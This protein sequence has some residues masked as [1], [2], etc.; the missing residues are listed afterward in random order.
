MIYV[1]CFQ[2]RAEIFPVIY[3]LKSLWIAFA[4]QKKLVDTSMFRQFRILLQHFSMFQ[5]FYKNSGTTFYIEKCCI[6]QI[7]LTNCGI[8]A[9]I[10]LGLCCLSVFQS[11]TRSL[12]RNVPWYMLVRSTVFTLRRDYFSWTCSINTSVLIIRLSEAY[13]VKSIRLSIRTEWRKLIWGI[14]W[15]DYQTV[16]EN[17][18]ASW[19]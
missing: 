18:S 2:S 13:I 5:Q 12:E 4:D 11:Y 9:R 7:K 15:Y 6:I 17:C 10:P 19:Q 1:L 14:W 3:Y 16:Q 8:K